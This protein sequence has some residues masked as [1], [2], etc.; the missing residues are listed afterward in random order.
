M[1]KD[2]YASKLYALKD[3]LPTIS[4]KKNIIQDISYMD[5]QDCE[6]VER[7]LVQLINDLARIGRGNLNGNEFYF[8]SIKQL[9][10]IAE[11]PMVGF[12]PCTRQFE[13]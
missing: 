5:I 7:V 12:S 1:L 9:Y 8:M 13:G 6:K 11:H 10:S 3:E 4:W 2:E